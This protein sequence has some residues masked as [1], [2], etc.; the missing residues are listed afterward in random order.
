MLCCT[1][2]YPPEWQTGRLGQLELDLGVEP[3]LLPEHELLVD[4]EELPQRLVVYPLSPRPH[5]DRAHVELELP[6]EV[7]VGGEG[8]SVQERSEYSEWLA[9]GCMNPPLRKSS[10]ETESRNLGAT[11]L[12]IPV[13]PEGKVEGAVLGLSRCRGAHSRVRTRGRPT[14]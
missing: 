13:G 11:F 1:V 7:H 12:S 6:T 8:L 14:L 5:V 2:V 10:Q 9:I 4:P 3:H